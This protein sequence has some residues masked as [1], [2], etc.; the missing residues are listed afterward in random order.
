MR[1]NGFTPTFAL[2]LSLCLCFAT[3]LTTTAQTTKNVGGTAFALPDFENE[4][5]QEINLA[6]TRPQDYA[7]YLEQLRPGFKGKLLRLS[8]S[9]EVETQEGT[10]A[11][12]EAITFLKG[13]PQLNPYSVSRGMSL[14]ANLLVQEQGAK[15]L[16]GHKGA[17]GSLCD[18]R[19]GRFG[20]LTGSVSENLSYG[21]LNARHRVLTWII[22]D[23][24]ASRGHRL[25]IFSRDFKL[26]GLSC[27]NHSQRTTMCVVAFAGGFD[28]KA[29][30]GNGAQSF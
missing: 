17:D 24:F 4:I 7:A 15:G 23:G 21:K 16:F 14:G 20:R 27:G 29:A 6:R 1:R 19:L 28:E 30:G 26:V 22:D 3:V 2:A 5:L 12:D 18:Q 8:G 9:H 11:L 10:A 25:S 13:A